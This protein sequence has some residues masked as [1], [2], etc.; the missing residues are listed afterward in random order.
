MVAMARAIGADV[1]AE[2]VETQEQHD[3]L[4]VLLR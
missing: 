1:V 4:V 2:G 3:C